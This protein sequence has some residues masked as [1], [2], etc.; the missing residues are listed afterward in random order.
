MIW[1]DN[2]GTIPNISN[3]KLLNFFIPDISVELQKRIAYH[4]DKKCG[5]IDDLIAIKQEK[6]EKLQ[7]YKKSL[8]YEYVTGKKEV[9]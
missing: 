4:L 9:V 3:T 7:E 2:G 8:I 5:K 1:F 6:I